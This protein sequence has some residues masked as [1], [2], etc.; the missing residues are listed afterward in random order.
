MKV[1][2][3]ETKR[4]NTNL[5]HVYSA[6]PPMLFGGS[7]FQ[8][9]KKIEGMNQIEAVMRRIQWRVRK[10]DVS[11]KPAVFDSWVDFRKSG[12]V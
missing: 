1:D 5:A 10:Q 2:Q 4:I 9:K 7:Q 6:A 8:R 11:R 12:C 3:D